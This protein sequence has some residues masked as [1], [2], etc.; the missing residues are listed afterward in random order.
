MQFQFASSFRPSLKITTLKRTRKLSPTIGTN[1]KRVRQLPKN[2][3]IVFAATSIH[4][5]SEKLSDRVFIEPLNSRQ[6]QNTNVRAKAHHLVS[7]SH[8]IQMSQK[9]E[10]QNACFKN[11]FIDVF[12]HQSL[13]RHPGHTARAPPFTRGGRV[14]TGDRLTRTVFL[15]LKE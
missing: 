9:I 8:G 10:Y 3:M 13:E 11:P 6:S 14:R 5:N 1:T 12:Y 2:D 7:I 4:F 15:I